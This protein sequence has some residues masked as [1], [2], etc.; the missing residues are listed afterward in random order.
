MYNNELKTRY[1]DERS[2]NFSIPIDYLKVQ[3]SKTE[4]TEVELDKDLSN[5]TT[6]EIIDFYKIMNFTSFE[7]LYCLNSYFSL[8]CQFC[9]ENSLVKDNQNHFLEISKDTIHN[10]LNK[11][12]LDKRIVSRET[13]LKWV[14]DLP[15]P[16]DQFILLSLFEY[17]KS[18]DFRDI[19]NAKQENVDINKHTLKLD[20]GRNVNISNKMLSIINQC[21][22]E[23]TYYS[24]TGKGVKVMPLIDHGY[25]VKSYPNANAYATDYQKG[26]N[27][28]IS[29]ARIFNYVDAGDWMSPNAIAESGKLYMIKQR[30]S[31]LNLTPMQYLYSK[32]INEVENQ[33]GCRITRSI[34]NKKY[35]EYLV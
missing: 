33:F 34:Y 2:K 11:A 31:E 27:I 29:C 15:N 10:C 30:A 9:L 12:I 21:K 28:Y 3:F 35:Q 32:H 18:K 24:I 16:K 25:I 17:G 26:R 5:W 14:D 8:Y 20:D 6:Y 23:N 22:E 7:V 19:V 4:E 13:I 1:L